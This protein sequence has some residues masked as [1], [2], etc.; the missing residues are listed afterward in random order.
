MIEKI[1]CHTTPWRLELV[2]LNQGTN[3]LDT[4]RAL[5]AELAHECGKKTPPPTL[6]DKT[7]KEIKQGIVIPVELSP[8]ELERVLNTTYINTTDRVLMAEQIAV[9]LKKKVREK[10]LFDK[11]YYEQTTKDRIEQ[12]IKWAEE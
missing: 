10:Y 1:V 9:D 2:A 6:V 5:D 8:E 7:D 4:F 3:K 12:L 11:Y